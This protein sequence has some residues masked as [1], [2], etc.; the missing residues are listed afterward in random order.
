MAAAVARECLAV[1]NAVGMLDASTLGKIEVVGPD[2]A[3]FLERTYINAFRGLPVGR[4]RYALLLREDGSVLDDGIA[5]RLAADR[6]HL[7]TT[8]G[9][10]ARVLH[11]L[12]DYLQTEFPDLR[13]WLTST[14]EHWAVIALQGPKA[15]DLLAPFVEGLDLSPDAFPHMSVAACRIAGI[16]ARLFRVSFTGE[17]GY[18]INLPAGQA[19]AL[20]QALWEAGQAQGITAYGTEA[21]HVLRAEK[22]YILLGQE[23]DGT[24]TP[25]DLGLGWAI[26]RRKPDFI[27]KRSLARPE[28]RRSHRLQL[29][30]LRPHDGRTVPDEGAQLLGAADATGPALGYVTS[31]YASATLGHPVALGLLAGGRGRHG[32]TV[33]ATRLDAAPLALVVVPPVFHDP[34]GRRLHV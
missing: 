27:G 23:A 3:E 12:E 1:R 15:R 29:V 17:L 8:T 21:M 34:D 14:T 20:W 9:G 33:F 24:A 5:G 19:P 22:G 2:A 11:L 7:T 4:C 6:F 30:G 26:G 28:M 18:E 25:E 16:P 10:A 31:A 32:E 13:V